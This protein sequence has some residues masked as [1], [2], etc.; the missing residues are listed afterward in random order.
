MWPTALI[1]A[2]A[3]AFGR[4]FSTGIL[5]STTMVT[6][7]WL[8]FRA[9]AFNP[10]RA[11]LGFTNLV[12]PDFSIKDGGLLLLYVLVVVV[13]TTVLQNIHFGVVRLLEGYWGTSRLA[14]ALVRIGVD[15]QR[16]RLLK[17]VTVLRTAG[18]VPVSGVPASSASRRLQDQ[19]ADRRAGARQ[20]LRKKHAIRVQAAYPPDLDELL[21]TRLGN[22]MRAGERRAGERYGWG[23]VPTWPRLFPGLSE[24]VAAAYRSARDALETA[25]VFCL[26]FLAITLFATA[27]LY[28]DPRLWWIPVATLVLAHVSYRGVVGSAVALGVIQQVAFDRHRFDLFEAMHISLPETPGEE[29]RQAQRLTDFFARGGIRPEVAKGHLA[30]VRYSHAEPAK[31]GWLRKLVPRKD[32]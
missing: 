5:P 30:G 12:P 26:T 13:I 32:Q 10:N 16:S 18:G 7:V 14:G 6:V 29:Y 11:G 19:A 25:A 17:A 9:D 23:T 28:D 27:A 1:T 8:L 24:P 22:V 15:R 21:P 4:L 31:W 20:E 2:G 3:S